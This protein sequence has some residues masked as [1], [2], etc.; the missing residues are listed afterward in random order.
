MNI[1]TNAIAAMLCLGVFAGTLGGLFGI[2]GGLVI[3]PFLVLAFGFDQRMAT[4]TSLFALL[5]PVGALAVLQ[6]HG[7][8]EVRFGHGAVIAVG[9]L[10][11]GY[12]GGRFAGLISPS[13]LKRLY[14]IFLVVV[15]LYFFVTTRPKPLPAPAAVGQVH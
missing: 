2:G 6:F 4:G 5:L 12:L 7:R 3:V 10:F 13:T 8:G 1:S 9:L 11:G 14:A 15:G